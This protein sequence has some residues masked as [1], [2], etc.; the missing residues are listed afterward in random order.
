MARK[1]GTKKEEMALSPHGGGKVAG[2]WVFLDGEVP[3][4]VPS[5]ESHQPQEATKHPMLLWAQGIIFL[6]NLV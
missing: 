6:Y 2:R 5:L 3:V 1:E 4:L